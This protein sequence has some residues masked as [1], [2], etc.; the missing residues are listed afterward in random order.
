[1][2]SH[3]NLDNVPVDDNSPAS[4]DYYNNF[5]SDLSLDSA[6]HRKIHIRVPSFSSEEPMSPAPRPASTI[7]EKRSSSQFD[8][9]D[10]FDPAK[11]IE[12][13]DLTAPDSSSLVR[14]RSVP[15]IDERESTSFRMLSNKDGD[16]DDPTIIVEPPSDDDDDEA[17]SEPPA[18]DIIHQAFCL[19]RTC[20]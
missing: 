12:T 10:D 7:A 3:S 5:D 14:S 4:A 9:S 8:P 16:V 2:T 11:I 13:L 6:G 15:S 1:M 19:M 18:R 20:G 17:A